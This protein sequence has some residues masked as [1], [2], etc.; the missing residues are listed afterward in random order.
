[1]ISSKFSGLSAI[2]LS[3]F[4][5]A[6]HAQTQ[7]NDLTDQK[8]KR[9]K[10]GLDAGYTNTSLSANISNLV[11][12]KYTSRGGFAINT[13]FEMNVYKD[14]FVASGISYM[15]R[16][17]DFERTNTREGWHSKYNN[18]F[19]SV[20]L[21]IGGY[22]L[23]NPYTSDGVWIKVAGGIY[24]EYWAKSKVKGTYPVFAELQPD[25]SFPLVE[26]SEKYDWS[27]NENQYHRMSMGLQGQIQLGYSINELDFYAGYSY[28]H[29]LTD[30]YK[31][32][33]PGSNVVRNTYMV[34]LGAAYK[35]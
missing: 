23:N 31:Y 34:T 19:I 10:V 12:S 14:L 26:A 27:K 35:F 15:Q 32:D 8:V 25:G 17:Y 13:S 11:D 5:M 18:D 33:H 4:S 1:M 7:P 16:N 2:I 6:M 28:L 30:T 29:G 20:P 9:F 21:S 22:L 24:A 3:V